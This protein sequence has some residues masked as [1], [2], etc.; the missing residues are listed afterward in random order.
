MSSLA[1]EWEPVE[2]GISRSISTAVTPKIF[3]SLHGVDV[4]HRISSFPAVLS[5]TFIRLLRQTTC[6]IT[7]GWHIYL[8][9]SVQASKCNIL[10]CRG[11]MLSTDTQPIMPSRAAPIRYRFG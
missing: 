2:L 4:E 6:L 7:T 3:L 5:W 9:L 11:L 8:S 1:S 10:T